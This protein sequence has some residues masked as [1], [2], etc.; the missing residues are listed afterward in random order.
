MGEKPTGI[1]LAPFS[2]SH[3]KGSCLVRLKT[4]NPSLELILAK[5][6]GTVSAPQSEEMIDRIMPL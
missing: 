3:W 2:D 6:I 1:S 4:K 5:C